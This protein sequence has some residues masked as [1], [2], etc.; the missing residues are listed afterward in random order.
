MTFNL[1]PPPCI[2]QGMRLLEEVLYPKINCIDSCVHLGL[3][4]AMKATDAELGS[5]GT[6]VR[7]LSAKLRLLGESS[8]TTHV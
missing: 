6:A 2:F 1:D 4:Q 7:S 8:V 3:Q 5:L